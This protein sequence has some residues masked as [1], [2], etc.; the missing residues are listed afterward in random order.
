MIFI[1][2]AKSGV[3]MTMST[4]RLRPRRRIAVNRTV[5]ICHAAAAVRKYL[6]TFTLIRPRVLWRVC[7][8]LS[9]SNLQPTRSSARRELTDSRRATETGTQRRARWEDGLG[10]HAT[11]WVRCN[12]YRVRYLRTSYGS[13]GRE[14]ADIHGKFYKEDLTRVKREKKTVY[15]ASRRLIPA[16]LSIFMGRANSISTRLSRI[17]FCLR[18]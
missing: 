9:H 2:S 14:S 4:Y 18:V 5:L 17:G 8:T 6:V 15:L 1:N 12:G 10:E 3:D 7:H 11:P 13:N 16:C